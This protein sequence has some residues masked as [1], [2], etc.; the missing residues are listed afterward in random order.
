[1]QRVCDRVAFVREGELVAVEEVAELMGRAVREVEVVFAEP[2]P[3]SA[4]ERVP[5]VTR[6]VADGTG[7][8]TL[9]LTVS[10]SLDPAVKALSAYPVVDLISQLP[11][12]EDVFMTFYQSGDDEGAT[13]PAPSGREAEAS[14]AP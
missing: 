14:H 12:L 9:R 5:G 13:H 6:V 1:V 8:N 2:V 7:A 10:G 11:D 4:F 3:P